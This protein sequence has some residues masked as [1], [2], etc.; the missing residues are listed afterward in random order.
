MNV[1]SE[2]AKMPGHGQ[3]ERDADERL[4]DQVGPDDRADDGARD[5]ERERS[6]LHDHADDDA[7][8]ATDD[9]SGDRALR[10]PR[11]GVQVLRRLQES[12]VDLL[13]RH[14]QRQRHERQEVVGDTGD[15]GG[16]R[17]E[18]SELLRQDRRPP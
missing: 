5:P 3:R 6:V 1:S 16:R 17:R 14:V 2:P 9:G 15:D 7:E 10:P 4:A 11:P 13:E 8:H 18:E 12:P